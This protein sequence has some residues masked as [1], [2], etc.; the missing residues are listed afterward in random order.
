[1][2]R[3]GQKTKPATAELKK[4]SG[5]FSGVAIFSGCINILM[6]TGSIYM[7]QVYDRVLASRSIP[8]LIGIS[9]IVLLAFVVQGILDSIRSR[10]LAR[11]GAEF[12]HK[13]SPT[14]FELMRQL[15][16]RGARSDQASQGTRDLDTV[17]GF[18]GSMGPTAFFDMP[19]MPIFF[20]GCFLLHPVL[21]VMAL[22][23]GLI[24]IG[25][26][27]WTESKTKEGTLAITQSGAERAM[28][29]EASRRNAEAIQ[30]MGMGRTFGERW[31]EVNARHVDATLT[32]TNAAGGVG[33]AA[34]VFRMA[35]QSAVLGVGAYLVIIQQM[36]PGAMIAASIL[37]SRAL[38]PIETAVAH[39]KGFVAS[40]QS[41]ARL[42]ELLAIHAAQ[43]EKTQLPAPKLEFAADELAVGVPGRQ[44]PLVVGASI[45]LKA[46]SALLIVGLSGSGKS[47]LARVLA[48]VWPPLRGTVRIDGATLD[49]WD[50]EQLGAHMGYM[51]QDVELFDGTVSQN[52]ARFLPD[53]SDDEIVSAAKAAGAHDMILKL[54]EGYGT[55]IGEGGAVLSA[56]QR[57]RVGLARALFRDPFLLVLDEPNSNL[58]AEGEMALAHAIEGAR[59]RGGIAIIVSHKTSLLQGVDFVGRVHEGRFQMIT[60]DEYRQNMMRAA[61]QAQGGASGAPNQGGVHAQGVRQQVAML[62]SAAGGGGNPGPSIAKKDENP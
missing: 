44:N 59:K 42:N 61:Q 50:S 48:G 35:F 36:T 6:L 46:G 17:R 5:S 45:T 49:Q 10:M 9:A 3:P 4:L 43:K 39:W 57:Q 14:V 33:A 22:V 28:L 25:L 30:S 32:V 12:D 20:I 38:A 8:T 26:T 19:F 24:I 60:R 2:A 34:K 54:S 55:R 15:P 7:L 56:G 16:L 1:M 37:T 23:G 52:I 18:L 47:T 53:A 58:D 13:L 11:I 21:G 41:F 51:P 31:R 27:L 62:R 29:A 40:R